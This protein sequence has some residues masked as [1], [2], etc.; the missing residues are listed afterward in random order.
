MRC[1]TSTAGLY[2][3]MSSSALQP[4]SKMT[5]S[6]PFF[7]AK[8]MKRSYVFV[9]A[10]SPSGLCESDITYALATPPEKGADFSWVK[11]GKVAWDWWNAFDNKGDPQGCTT[12]TYVRFIDF[13]AKTGVEYVIFDEGWSAKLNIWEYS[14]KVDVPYL[15]GEGNNWKRTEAYAFKPVGA[16]NWELRIPEMFLHHGELY[17]LWIE[18]PGGGGERLPAYVTRVVQDQIGRAHV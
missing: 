3:Q 7:A 2:F 15:I 14:P 17:K 5:Y 16:G 1:G 11:P 10:D 9:L 6:T 18:W 12:E 4:S 8:S 13:A